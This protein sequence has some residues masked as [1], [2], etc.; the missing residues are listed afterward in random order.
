VRDALSLHGPA[1][2]FISALGKGD[3]NTVNEAA[4]RRLGSAGR[5]TPGVEL[6]F[7]DDE[8]RPLPVGTTGEIWIR[9]RATIPGYYKNP[10]ATAAEFANGFWKSGAGSPRG[11]RGDC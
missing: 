1:P 8:G 7:A 2:Q 10:E 9:A 3:H 4:L 11:R 5:I 6:I